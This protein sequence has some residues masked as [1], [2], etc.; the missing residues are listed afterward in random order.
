MRIRQTMTRG[1]ALAALL[2][3]L[4][5]GHAAAQSPTCDLALIQQTFTNAGYAQLNVAGQPCSM[6][7][8]NTANT[9]ANAAQTA[10]QDLGANLASIQDQ[11]ENDALQQALI[12]AGFGNAVVWIG[13]HFPT[14][15]HGPDDFEW[16]DGSPTGYTNWNPG[17]PNNNS[18]VPGVNENCMQM[19]VNNGQWNDLVCGAEPLGLGPTGTSVIEVNLCPQVTVTGL[20]GQVCTGDVVNLSSQ[21]MFGSTPYTYA[22]FIA[23][24]PVPAAMGQNFS[25]TVN[26]TTTYV[27]GVQDAYSCGDTAMFTISPTACSDCSTFLPPTMSSTPTAC[28]GSTGTAT[29]TPQGGTGPYTAAWNTVPPQNGLTATGLA[30]GDYEV[31]VTDADNCV[32]T[33]TVNVGTDA[34][35]M[36][37]S[38]TDVTHPTCAGDCD[39]QAT[40]NVQGGDAPFAYQWSTG[41]IT[42]TVL[43]LCDGTHS[44]TVTDGNGCEATATVEITEPDVLAF[45][46]NTTATTCPGTPTGTAS[47]LISGGTAP[48]GTDWAG[49]DPTALA[50]GDYSVT[51]SDAN[52]C[53]A[54]ENFTIAQGTGLSLAL[55]ITDN[56]CFGG[57]TGQAAVV[58][59]NGAAPYDIAWTDAFGNPIQVNPGT[60]GNATLTGLP[61]G[62]YNVGAQDVTG[63]ANAASFTITQPSQPL[64]L[65]LT[66]QHLQCHQASDGAV[67]ASQNGLP[68]FQYAISDI[69]G[70]P[71]GNAVNAAAHTFTGLGADTYFVTVVDANGCQNTDT[72][73]LNQPP[74][75][76]AEGLAMPI[77]CF[78]ADDGMAQ[79]TS[80]T[81]GTPPYQPTQWNPGNQTGATATGLG[82]GN[83]TATVTDANGCTLELPF[84]VTGPMQMQ[85]SMGYYTDTCGLGKGAAYAN[86]SFGSP[87]YTYLWDSPHAG[88][89]FR[90]NGLF[91]GV[92]AVTVTDA[93]GCTRT[94]SVKVQD[95]LPYPMADFSSRIE[96]EHVMDQVVQFINSS[97]GTVSWSWNFGDG[98]VSNEQ[99]PRHSYSQAGDYL[100]QL[101]AS[102]GYCSDT[103]YGYVNIDP[104]LAVYVP[105]AFTP[106]IN[107]INDYFFPQG[108]GFEEESYDMFIYDRWGKLV[109]RTGNFNRKWNGTNMYSQQP[110][111]GG[112]Y[113]WLIRFR[114]FADNDRFELRGKVHLIR[115]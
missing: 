86:A 21:A 22:W 79:V 44:V 100:V 70:T 47:V 101:M 59:T 43:T 38:I 89:S 42:G 98:Q 14:A 92:Y 32:Q 57:S 114:K 72:V 62:V 82:P 9:S 109:W 64:T 108:E 5:C 68:P 63:C 99:D 56:V 65:T 41:N 3:A 75:L 53:E 40:A 19:V 112:V 87:P 115:D 84:Q 18:G 2:P 49:Q 67:T 50:E 15:A 30:A 13:G 107:N 20:G 66:P 104:L 61:S 51:V 97:I 36:T 74:P 12:D 80:V 60:N 110:S 28:S 1:M 83:V 10:A 96:G 102:N 35:G 52:G 45:T 8:Y 90:E 26:A 88:T 95:D 93:N 69:F 6:Y 23:P 81:G 25:P 34:G 16:F 48:F 113:T 91:E 4:L 7:F 39:G 55:S 37:V 111:P 11:T 76:E 46:V 17:E 73:L 94:D 29:A 31:T 33:A 103:A 54:T 85:L 24:S 77:S 106:G 58:V 71:L 78:G 105:N 27:A